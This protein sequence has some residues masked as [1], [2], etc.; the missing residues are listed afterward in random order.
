MTTVIFR[1]YNIYGYISE[2]IFIFN[3]TLTAVII[4]YYTHRQIVNKGLNIFLCALTYV[5]L[6]VGFLYSYHYHYCY[7]YFYRYRCCLRIV[8]PSHFENF[9][10]F[11]KLLKKSVA[12]FLSMTVQPVTER[13]QHFFRWISDCSLLI[14]RDWY[15]FINPSVRTN[16]SESKLRDS[17]KKKCCNFSVT[18]VHNI[19]CKTLTAF[20]GLN[21]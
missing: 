15:L 6:Y 2:H 19:E 4:V 20:S 16:H 17:S 8:R 21:S 18:A 13:L 11:Q 7:R 5:F 3:M 10:V 14:E 12:T 9:C 1:T